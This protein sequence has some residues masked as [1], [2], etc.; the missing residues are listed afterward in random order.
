MKKNSSHAIARNSVQIQLDGVGLI[1]GFAHPSLHASGIA[2][3]VA[4]CIA[5]DRICGSKLRR[6]DEIGA[7]GV[8]TQAEYRRTLTK[9]MM[10]QVARV[11]AR[12]KASAA[13]LF[14][15]IFAENHPLSVKAE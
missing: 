2:P 9:D 8:A 11:S 7:A 13:G 14:R 6:G 10:A 3:T 5:A 4:K 15:V 12:S 1:I